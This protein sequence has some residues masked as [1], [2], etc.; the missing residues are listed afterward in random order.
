M[1]PEPQEIEHLSEQGRAARAVALGVAF[2][3]V[4]WLLRRRGR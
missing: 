2:G 3:L 4:L 1:G